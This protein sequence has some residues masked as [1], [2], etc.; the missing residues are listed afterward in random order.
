LLL[1]AILAPLLAFVTASTSAAQ[2]SKASGT[3]EGTISDATGGRIPGVKVSLRQTET[4]QTR[5]V[6][7]DDQG[8]FRA[9]DLTVSTYEVRAEHA[10]FAAY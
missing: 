4:N 6:T 10:G 8:F 2:A 5:A 9:T 1:G 3:L 7:T